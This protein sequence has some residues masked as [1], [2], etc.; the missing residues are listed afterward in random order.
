MATPKLV[1]RFV[2][3]EKGQPQIIERGNRKHYWIELHVEDAPSDTYAVNYQLHDDYYDPLR[4][5][6]E[7]SAGF[8]ERLT[9]YGDYT[10]Q[11]KLRTKSHVDVLAGELSEALAQ[12]HSG[13]A[14]PMIMKAL[15]D[16]RKH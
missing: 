8:V 4:E 3:D 6:R 5:S 7:S 15:D 10:V 13:E 2:L 16:I 12:G 11:A 1:A 14:S 9:S